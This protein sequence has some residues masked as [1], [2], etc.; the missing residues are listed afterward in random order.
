MVVGT[1]IILTVS[2]LSQE[3]GKFEATLGYTTSLGGIAR[4]WLKNKQNK[5]LNQTVVA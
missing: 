4:S 1:K 2:R 5:N 3:V